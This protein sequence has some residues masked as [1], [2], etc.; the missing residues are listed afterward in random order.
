MALERV[1]G[2]DA[3]S[4][5]VV[6]AYVPEYRLGHV[7]DHTDF[8]LPRATDLLLFSVEPTADGTGLQASC[9]ECGF[10]RDER[11]FRNDYGVH[12][13]CVCVCCL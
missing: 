7:H 9:V 8:I 13:V 6:T 10:P 4:R 12:V 11:N 3:S 5:F 1:E 2:A